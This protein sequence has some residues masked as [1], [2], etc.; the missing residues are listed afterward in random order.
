M[1]TMEATLAS[2]VMLF[3][4][5]PAAPQTVGEVLL[6]LFAGVLVIVVI[7]INK[8]CPKSKRTCGDVP[9]VSGSRF[10]VGHA[11]ELNADPKGLL[12]RGR[13]E[14]GAVFALGGLAGRQMVVVGSGKLKKQFF[15]SPRTLSF[16]EAG[17]QVLKPEF[18]FGLEAFRNGWHVGIIRREMAFD[19]V[20]AFYAGNQACVERCL[21]QTS[22]DGTKEPTA[23]P[24]ASVVCADLQALAWKLIAACSAR[25]FVGA[26]LATNPKFLAV[27]VD[28]HKA[29]NDVINAAHVMPDFL[30]KWLVAR[31]VR[32]HI[33]TVAK[34]VVP[35]VVRRRTTAQKA[36]QCPMSAAEKMSVSAAQCPVSAAQFPPASEAQCPVWSD[37]PQHKDLLG[38][39]IAT[40]RPA[41]DLA[42]RLM[43]MI[44]A[45]MVTSAGVLSHCLH[46]L[47]G[48][49]EQWAA[50]VAEQTHVLAEHSWSGKWT[51]TMLDA[52]PYLHAF[53]LESMRVAAL[54][55]QQ[56]RWTV[57]EHTFTNLNQKQN[58]VP[59]N[60]MVLMSGLLAHHDATVIKNPAAFRP[61]RFLEVDTTTYGG[62]GRV[63]KLI[64][65]PEAT[66]FP[67]G[68]GAR[69]CAGRH[70]ALAEIKVALACIL[71]RFRSVTTVSGDVPKYK[72]L[73]GDCVRV[74]EP[75]VFE[76]R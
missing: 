46:D 13:R 17:I 75:A 56:A 51:K 40:D 23:A 7:F 37:R 31:P 12:E 54:P 36:A 28:F 38:A 10:F 64:E 68:I 27:F 39:M 70:F 21:Q 66:F 44:F 32:R 18:S 1:I 63:W 6:P 3:D 11:L 14:H 71:Q 26:E 19:T 59:K 20:A 9:M 24:P 49:P 30:L 60:T 8:F 4:A 67:F 69:K 35:E 48:R 57:K 22:T 42:Q 34:L 74:L 15:E 65:D 76:F 50:L 29:C 5:F 2:I 45:S 43:P 52:C 61:E 16:M 33:E 25:A 47:A 72:W 55:F 62:G 41:E 58:I 73:P 53:I